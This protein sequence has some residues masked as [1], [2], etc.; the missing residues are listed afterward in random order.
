ERSMLECDYPGGTVYAVNEVVIRGAT[1]M[2]ALD[3]SIND[4][5]IRRIRGDGLIVGTSTGSTAYLLSAGCPIVMPEV[6][7]MILAGLNEYN[8]T[9]RHLIVDHTSEIKI[10]ITAFTRETDIYLSVDGKE[11]LPLAI[12]DKIIVKE[13]NLRAK[14][15]FMD[16]NYFFN[17]LS[18]RLAW[19]DGLNRN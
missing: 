11:K 13:S 3:L 5:H 16:S 7:C 9:A 19:N 15:I 4:Q 14:L 17:N 12:N 6:R 8:F 2:I 10:Q 1:H 18:T